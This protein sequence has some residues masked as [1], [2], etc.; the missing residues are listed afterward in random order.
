MG[1]IIEKAKKHIKR[2]QQLPALYTLSPQHARKLRAVPRI[3]QPVS[4]LASIQ[5]VR[6]AVKDGD[7]VLR[8]YTPKN[9]GKLGAI[10]YIHGGGWVINSI[11]TSDASCRL[12]AEKT[13]RIVISVDY[14]LAPEHA[15]PVPVEDCEAAFQWVVQHAAQYNIDLS[16]IAI[17]GDSAGGNLATV[18]ANTFKEQIE[19]QILLYPVTNACMN[20]ASYHTYAQGCGLDANVMAWFIEQY[21]EVTERTNPRVSPYFADVTKA[22]KAFIVVAENDVLKDEGLLYAQ[23]L[24]QA[25]V[26]VEAVEMDGLIHSYFTT[27]AVFAEE[28]EQTIARIVSFL[29]K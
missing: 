14:R 2:Q 21:V 25:G 9:V 16:R 19:A 27:N 15:F 5:D 24:Q 11:D 18:V 28:I 12:L 23:K 3:A 20:T 29:G 17:A 4:P 7:I 13:G 6:I 8:I 22:P 10:V 1:T 26:D